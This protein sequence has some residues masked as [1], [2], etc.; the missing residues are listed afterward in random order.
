MPLCHDCRLPMKKW[1]EVEVKTTFS[2][3][4]TEAGGV[5]TNK[6]KMVKVCNDCIKKR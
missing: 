4:G 1:T 5:E 6:S 2:M 3:C